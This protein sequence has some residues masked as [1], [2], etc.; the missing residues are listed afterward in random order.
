MSVARGNTTL[1]AGA[2]PSSGV[3]LLLAIVLILRRSRVAFGAVVAPSPSCYSFRQIQPARVRVPAESFKS[4]I[5]K[6]PFRND[7]PDRRFWRSQ[8]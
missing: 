5:K 6:I 1:G 7:L 2:N 4:P 3:V 8:F